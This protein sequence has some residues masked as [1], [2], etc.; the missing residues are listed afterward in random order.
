M[1]LNNSNGESNEGSNETSSSSA[2]WMTG[3]VSSSQVNIIYIITTT[4]L[5]GVP[6][7]S[8]GTSAQKLQLQSYFLSH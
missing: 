4:I 7:F 8:Y 2:V 5:R 3:S 1:T 6:L